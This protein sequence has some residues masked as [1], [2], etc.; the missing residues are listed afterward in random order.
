[1]KI[2]N[3]LFFQI[4]NRFLW[5]FHDCH[6]FLK[7]WS[8]FHVFTSKNYENHEKNHKNR[9]R[10]WKIENSWFY[11]KIHIID[12]LDTNI[13]SLILCEICTCYLCVIY[14]IKIQIILENP[15]NFYSKIINI[16]KIKGGGSHAKIQGNSWR[17]IRGDLNRFDSFRF[18]RSRSRSSKLSRSN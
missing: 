6:N 1:M 17:R 5:F 13:K 9:F 16:T 15:Y 11:Q 18:T 2:T 4:L 12:N 14:I 3:F 7:F 10:I 8:C